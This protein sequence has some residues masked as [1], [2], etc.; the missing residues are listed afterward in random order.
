VPSVSLDPTVVSP[1]RVNALLSCG[2]AFKMKYVDG[3]PEQRSGSAALRG[4]VLHRAL[5]WWA[6]DRQQDLRP[7]VDK[8]WYDVTKG[9]S[10]E[11]F[12]TA[13]KGRSARAIVLEREI[14][15]ARPDVKKVRLTKDW[16]TS[17]LAGEIA[18]LI[19]RWQ[20]RLVAESPWAFTE[21]DPLPALYDESVQ[22]ADVYA[23]RAGLW[24]N[25]WHGEFGFEERWRGFTL[26]GYIDT[27]EPVIT[28]DGELG[29][30]LVNDYKSYA[31]EPPEFKD[32]R[33][34]V[35]YYAVVQ[36]LVERGAIVLPVSLDEV[37]L[38]IGVDYLL[39]KPGWKDD[40]GRN[41][42]PRRYWRIT[43]A[44][45]DR[46]EAELL[47]YKGIVAGGHFLPA[48][49]GFNPDFCPYPEACCLRSTSAAG[50]GAELVTV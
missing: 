26:K 47:S 22:W 28:G 39:W 27:I 49:K 35:M 8:A 15:E 4:S 5:E 19:R 12:I 21:R 44:D 24:P 48:Q 13:Y 9:T 46:L 23:A 29:A 37:P 32:Y 42:P 3:L 38:L 1:S 43:P 11:P 7:L 16:K 41:F 20:P 10:V 6:V 50:G 40:R 18:R 17:G 34:C 33:Q 2:T 30:V 25:I 36:A 31:K 45:L 14:R